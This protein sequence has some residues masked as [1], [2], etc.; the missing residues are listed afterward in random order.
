MAVPKQQTSSPT[1]SARLDGRRIVVTGANR[2]IGRAVAEAFVSSGASVIVHS[3]EHASALAAEIGAV[4]GVDGDLRDRTLA[5]R[6]AAAVATLGGLD[7]LVLNAA[8][9]GPMGPLE[10]A[11]LAAFAEVMDINVDSQLAIFQALLPALLAGRDEGSSG[12][13]WL[14]SALGRIGVPG[15]GAY[16]ASKHAVE[17][18]S[19]LAH[20]EYG[21]RGLVSVTVAPGMVQTE[22][23]KAALGSDDVSQHTHPSVVGAA[24]TRLAAALRPEH[25]GTALEIYNF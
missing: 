12:V 9:L 2:G 20:A 22:M 10:S 3:R 15:Y 6:L 19:K 13:I 18:L 25:S 14:S 23:L 7:L 11:D 5:S 21:S 24:F 8:V 1:K 17:G 4:A 16:C